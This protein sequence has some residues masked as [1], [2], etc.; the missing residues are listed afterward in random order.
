MFG[1]TW[2]GSAACAVGCG[3][4]APHGAYRADWTYRDYRA[5]RCFG[6]GGGAPHIFY[7]RNMFFSING[8]NLM[9]LLLTLRCR[10]PCRGPV[11][12]RAAGCKHNG[13]RLLTLFLDSLKLRNFLI[14]VK[15]AA[16]SRCLCGYVYIPS[17]ATRECK[18]LMFLHIFCVRLLQVCSFYEDGQCEGLNELERATVRPSRILC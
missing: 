15:N 8:A 3:S 6:T 16:N 5:L 10:P 17:M 13:K 12:V 4:F 18:P 9:N 7:C 1:L 11:G 2:H 14:F